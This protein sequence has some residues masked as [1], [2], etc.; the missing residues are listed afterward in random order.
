MSHRRVLAVLVAA[1]ATSFTTS[2]QAAPCT[3]GDVLPSTAP[4]K[5]R[6][7][8]LCLLNQQRAAHSLGRLRRNRLLAVAAMRHTQDMVAHQYFAHDS[9]NGRTFDVRIKATGYLAGANGWAVGE[10][11]AWGSG[12]QATPRQ[13]VAAWMASPPHRRNILDRHYTQIGIA[14]VNHGPIA[15]AETGAATYTTEFGHRG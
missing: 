11:L 1:A 12:T 9:L 5:A 13:I 2:A 10:N 4:A 8:T 14:I 7:A 6:S 3:A 15:E